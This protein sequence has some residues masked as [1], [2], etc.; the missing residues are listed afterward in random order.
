M[1]KGLHMRL[2]I[3][4]IGLAGGLALGA[5][6]ANA[7]EAKIAFGDLAQDTTLPVEVTAQE[8]T[9]NNADGTA[10]FT[11][12]VKVVQGEMTL[13]AGEVRVVYDPDGNAI[14]QLLASGGV[15]ITNLGDA[16]TANQ[17]DYTIDSGVIVLTGGVRL[18]QGPSAMAGEKLTINLKDGTGVMEGG[19]T[20]TFVPGGN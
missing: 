4:L 1:P 17:A 19:V 8:F 13:T 10:V 11:G 5:V 9:V 6:L 7:Q 18:A 14:R 16:A 15:S 2:R 12:A 3:W 20:T